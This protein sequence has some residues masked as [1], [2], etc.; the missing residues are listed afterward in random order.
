MVKKEP[1]LIKHQKPTREQAFKTAVAAIAIC[2]LVSP[3]L[4]LTFRYDAYF[5]GW[6]FCLL[7]F[8]AFEGLLLQVCVK[9][10]LARD[11]FQCTLT[12]DQIICHCPLKSEGDSFKLGIFEVNCIEEKYDFDAGSRYYLVDSKG[13]RFW[14]TH[15]YD[16]PV[17]RI[18]DRLKILNPKIETKVVH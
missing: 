18:L 4:F 8:I 11:Q 17:L 15:G 2:I 9:N 14:L 3:L 1:F 6:F 16:N 7:L 10:F 13:N 5:V 12:S